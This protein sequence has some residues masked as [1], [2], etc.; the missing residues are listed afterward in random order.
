MS[1]HPIP[2]IAALMSLFGSDLNQI[3]NA[4]HLH[5]KSFTRTLVLV[6]RAA[7]TLSSKSSSLSSC[8]ISRVCSTKLPEVNSEPSQP[9]QCCGWE[10]PVHVTTSLHRV[11]RIQAEGRADDAKCLKHS[12]L[13]PKA[14][15]Y[16]Q[17]TL[18]LFVH[19]HSLFF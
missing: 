11:S 7:S 19:A 13:H 6:G 12:Q 9:M 4:L 17:S 14:Q 5:L 15:C 3:W 16:T 10:L 2:R 18:R 1:V 8:P